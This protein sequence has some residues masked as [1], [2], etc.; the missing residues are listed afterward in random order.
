[1][2]AVLLQQNASERIRPN[3]FEVV[4]PVHSPMD[5]DDESPRQSD[6][7][8]NQSK[9]Y[10]VQSNAYPEQP[11][12]YPERSNNSSP[13]T[14]NHLNGSLTPT[15]I[16]RSSASPPTIDI[17]LADDTYS[18]DDKSSRPIADELRLA[19]GELSR[20]NEKEICKVTKPFL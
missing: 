5:T 3:D 2:T 12:S 18:T 6:Y 11:D 16:R 8:T 9:G 4:E 1:M 19:L 14:D 17:H 15:N 13:V 20:D 10:T 7:S